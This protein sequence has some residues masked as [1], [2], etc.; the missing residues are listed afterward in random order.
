MKSPLDLWIYQE[1][2]SGNR[3]DV[4]VETGTAFGGSAFFLATICD[5]I[6]TGRI[7]TWISRRA[8]TG[9]STQDHI[10]DRRLGGPGDR[11]A[12]CGEIAEGESVMVTLDSRHHRDHVLAEMRAYGPLRD[13]GPVPRRRGHDDQ[14]PRAQ[15][16]GPPVPAAGPRDAVD[17]FLAE[18]DRFELDRSWEKFFM[19]VAAGGFLRR[20]GEL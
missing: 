5:L 4:I 1:L 20:V 6:G 17:E 8:T 2:V 13:R 12:R 9:R 3:P 7:V 11:L 15:A 19:T 14:S 18:Q 16:K 10:P